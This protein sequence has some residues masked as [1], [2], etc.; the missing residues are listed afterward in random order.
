M[1]VLRE[2]VLLF[3][4]LEIVNVIGYLFGMGYFIVGFCVLEVEGIL[5]GKDYF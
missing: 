2:V 5:L 4:V 3:V 1:F